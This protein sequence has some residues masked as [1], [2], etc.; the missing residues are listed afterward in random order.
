MNPML[1]LSDE[2]RAKYDHLV[3]TLKGTMP[4]S[5]AEAL[6]ENINGLAEAIAKP[7]QEDQRALGALEQAGVDNW[8]GYDDAM[9]ILR[10]ED[11]YA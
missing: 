4:A 5:L 10:G 3:S 9:A 2:A 7:Y 6:I 8:G 11:P 1:E